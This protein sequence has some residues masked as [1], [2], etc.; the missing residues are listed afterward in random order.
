ML[1]ATIRS[2]L[3]EGSFHVISPSDFMRGLTLAP[4]N[5]HK[6]NNSQGNDKANMSMIQGCQNFLK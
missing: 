3:A 6:I 2:S 5:T 4:L 1:E